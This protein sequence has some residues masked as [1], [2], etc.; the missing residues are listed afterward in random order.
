MELRDRGACPD[1]GQ[2][3][4]EFAKV[5]HA[6]CGPELLP[7]CQRF[8]CNTAGLFQFSG[9]Q[10]C[11][12]Q[13]YRGEEVAAL[14]GRNSSE[15]VAGLAPGAR[16]VK[17]FSNIP[18]EWIQDFSGQKPRTV[19]FVASDHLDAKDVVVSLI[20]DIGFA[21]VDTGDLAAGKI[22]QVA[23]PPSGLDLHLIRRMR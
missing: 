13:D 23:A 7:R 8:E 17:A 4:A 3:L 16:V 14:E 21:P 15:I 5:V 9:G 18:M 11:I 2:A 10:V 12:G 6:A 1:G 19:I 22:H 20:N